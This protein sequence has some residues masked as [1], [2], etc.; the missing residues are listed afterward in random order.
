P[1]VLILD[2]TK[3]VSLDTT[4]LDLLQTL[5]RSLEKRGAQ[6]ILCGLN[7]QPASLVERAGFGQALGTHGISSSL[8]DAL[9]R[10]QL[11][12]KSDPVVADQPA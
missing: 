5:H 3:T 2:M 8:T 11:I 10:A 1:R 4:G 6:L 7:A 12:I 9:L